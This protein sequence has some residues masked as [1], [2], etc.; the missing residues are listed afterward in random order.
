MPNVE[1]LIDPID[2]PPS[3]KRRP[4]WLRDTLQDVKRH[5]A[6]RGTFCESK[7]PNKY[8]GYLAV[9]STIVQSK[10]GTFEEAVKH[11][12]LKDTMHE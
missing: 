4:S 7:K 9:M 12:V 1:G 5:I 10:L 8:Q 11:Q 3:N 2:P 6:L